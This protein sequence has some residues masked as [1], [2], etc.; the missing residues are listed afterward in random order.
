MNLQAS[1]AGSATRRSR[2]GFLGVGWIG[3]NRM[4]AMIN[5]G[6]IDAAVIADVSSDVTKAAQE[7]APTAR[8][9][10]SFEALLEHDLDAVVIAT[11]SAQHA[12]QSI[13]ALERGLAVFCQKPLGRT[14]SEVA[15]V[16]DAARRADR[17]LG[18]DLSYRYTDGMRQVRNL[19]RTG[20]LGSIF[21]ADMIFHNAY[22]PDKPWFYDKAI[23]GG[24]CVIDLGVHL[25]DLAL[26][27]LDFPM[28]RK[29]ES[30]IFDN[31][32]PLVDDGHRVEDYA[33]ATIELET[34]AII[35]IACSWRLHAGCDARIQATFHGTQG[36]AEMR[37]V[38][39]SF[40]DFVTE[41]F[42]GTQTQVLS[43]PP[44]EW[45]GRAAS[46]WAG[47]LAAGAGFDPACERLIDVAAILDQIY[48]RAA[49]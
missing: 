31:G 36:S 12:E 2:I 40:Y 24:G 46:D 18:V 33:N 47:K 8:L 26:W 45:S 21:A 22:G 11:P 9:E 25:V 32:H 4:K 10:N 6:L 15:L 30:A 28:V 29:I 34:G 27:A 48:L 14:A 19:I 44:E 39:G 16:V 38:N 42:E 20:E 23:S 49:G 13:Q 35:R 41:R 7:L 3:R 1:I 5:T 43:S 17:L 37:N